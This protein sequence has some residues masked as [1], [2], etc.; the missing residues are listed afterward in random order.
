MIA[1]PSFL[2]LSLCLLG[3]QLASAEPPEW[4][5]APDQH[6]K[7]KTMLGMMR[8]DQPDLIVEPGQR[9]KLTLENADDLQHNLV[10]L[11][12][13]SDDSNGLKFATEMWMLGEK[14]MQIGWVQGD[15]KRVLATS[16]L[17]NPHESEDLYLVA[18]MEP[19]DYPYVCTVPGHAMI[20]NGKLKVR[21]R[22]QLIQDLTY[23]LYEGDWNK[24]PD[25]AALEPK[26]TGKV[27]NGLIDAQVVK[28][29]GSYGLVFKGKLMIEKAGDY[30][31]F[32]T[33]DDGSRL[34]IDGEPVVDHDGVHPAGDIRKKK[35]PLVA[36]EH[37][38]EVRY[39]DKG[40]DKQLSLT[41]KGPGLGNLPL[42]SW[43]A[44]ESRPKDKAPDPIPVKPEAPDEAVVYRNFL[45]G[46]N[47]R[48]IAVGYPGGVNICWDADVNNLTM[49][50][51]GGFMDASRHWIN[52]G[53]GNQG[54]AGYDMVK[55]GWG[56]PLQVL[57][58]P[59]EAWQDQVKSTIAYGK[60]KVEKNE[61]KQWVSHHEDYRFRGYRLDAKRFPTFRYEFQ[62]L[63]VEDFYTPAREGG[64]EAIQRTVTFKGEPAANTFFR[65]ADTGPLIE[66]GGWYDAGSNLK[67]RV[68][69]A[70][71]EVRKWGRPQLIVPVAADQK[72]EITYAWTTA[73][74]GRVDTAAK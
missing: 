12:P 68:Q 55:T 28:R 57:E 18:P 65:I 54:P 20:M 70:T 42:T 36:G 40:G 38:I 24:I 17:L 14:G 39:F 30:E 56:Y 27:P 26:G 64:I 47:P 46:P 9:I 50:W 25:F 60:D 15:H 35:I 2:A 4:S 52:R 49:V 63:S 5:G 73:V 59:E 34:I 51:R 21:V 62:K 37:S 10:F 61:T 16:R 45:A 22:K 1:K 58:T 33:S 31:F 13:Q 43:V 66:N 7:L 48:G 53:A 32:L 71:P 29:R 69:G 72:L 23:T 67:I 8:Y 3:F 44:N 11:R 19:G 6:L 74:G 41:V